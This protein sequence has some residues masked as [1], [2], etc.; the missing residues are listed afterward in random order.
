MKRVA[1]LFGLLISTHAF[2][3]NANPPNASA[4]AAIEDPGQ[5][6][7]CYDKQAGR[8]PVPTPAPPPASAPSSNF[9]LPPPRPAPAPA[10]APPPAPSPQTFGLYSAEHPL[11]AVDPSLTA[12]V[13]QLGSDSNGRSTVSLEGGQIWELLDE[14]D[15]VLR[16]GESVTIRRAVLGSFQMTTPSKRTHR[17]RRLR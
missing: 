6:L 7:A 8:A 16:V 2:S 12:N 10:P 17:V 3:Q 13:T 1:P 4:C 11:P 9:G 14:A 15:P 5:R